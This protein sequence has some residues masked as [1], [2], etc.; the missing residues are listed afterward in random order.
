MHSL[1]ATLRANIFT[2]SLVLFLIMMD[3]LTIIIHMKLKFKFKTLK[4]YYIFMYFKNINFKII[5]IN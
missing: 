2:V 1:R 3:L 4:D 5:I